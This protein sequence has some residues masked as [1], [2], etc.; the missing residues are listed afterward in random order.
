MLEAIGAGVSPR[1]GDR[2][3][4]DVWQDSPE[5]KAVINEIA[6]IKSIGL[7]HAESEQKDTKMCKCTY[8]SERSIRF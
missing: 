3:W 6:T 8:H 1:I 2:D 7:T 4:K 5:Y